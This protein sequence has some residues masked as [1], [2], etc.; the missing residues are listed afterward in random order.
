MRTITSET[1]R[2]IIYGPYDSTIVPDLEFFVG[3][4]I[5][6]HQ[7]QAVAEAILPIIMAEIVTV[8]NLDLTSSWDFAPTTPEQKETLIASAC[9]HMAEDLRASYEA[10]VASL[11]SEM[12]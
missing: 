9:A 7:I 6:S 5:N 2:K 10:T 1:L 4:T 8:A 11:L 12:G 3:E